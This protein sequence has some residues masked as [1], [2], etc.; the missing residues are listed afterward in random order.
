MADE[1]YEIEIGITT[2]GTEKSERKLS[3]MEKFIQ[4]TEKRAKTLDK[5]KISP[6]ASLKDKISG[7]AS[8]IEARLKALSSKK[9]TID[10]KARDLASSVISKITSPLALL[11]GTAATYGL[12]SIT[13]GQAMDFETQRVSMEHWLGGNKALANEATAWL[14]S[15]AAKT[16]FE[17]GDLF[18][19]MSRAIGVSEGDIEMSERL[20]QLSADMSGLTPGKTVQD[21]MEALADAQM[22][23]FERLKEFNM[24][25]TQDEMKKLGSFSGFLGVVEHKFAGGAEK[26]SQTAKGR[27][28]TIVDTIKTLFRSAGIGI[29][30]SLKPRLEKITDWFDK[31]PKTIE[32]WKNALIDFGQEAAEGLLGSM[33]KA[34]KHIRVR[35]LE[36]P[37][38]QKLDFGSKVKFA[39]DDMMKG[40]NDWLDGSGG[41][42]ISAFMEKMGRLFAIALDTTVPLIIPS[43]ITM[44]EAIGKGI[45]SGIKGAVVEG[46]TNGDWT[47]KLIDFYGNTTLPGQIYDLSKIIDYNIDYFKA[48]D[49]KSDAAKQVENENMSDASRNFK[50][51]GDELLNANAMYT[52]SQGN[53]QGSLLNLAQAADS[54]SNRLRNIGTGSSGMGIFKQLDYSTHAM[55]GILSRPHLGMVA[56]AGPEAIIPLSSRLRSR[57]VDIWYQAGHML[58]VR[59]YASGGFVGTVPALAG[60]GNIGVNAYVSLSMND[61]IDE[62]ALAMHIGRKIVKQIKQVLQNKG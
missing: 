57:A 45:L 16:P 24:K 29:L 43:A 38:F 44:G 9:I 8:K 31:H 40:A 51:A 20:L 25:M 35:Y 42:Q 41:T 47:A 14:E 58:G 4:K 17:M 32:K 28:S 60:T 7:A 21:A 11:G 10:I 27:L 23:E 26:L 19:A 33:E 55:G 36:N 48:N 12:G 34:F 56:E 46:V 13:L 2:E 61:N 53:L 15:I 39:M 22:G 3:A 18:S 49:V 30:E 37:E 54:A 1:R 6:M 59:Q 62:D 5:M 52:G 50:L